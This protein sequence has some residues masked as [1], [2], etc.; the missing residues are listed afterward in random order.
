VEAIADSTLV[1]IAEQQCGESGGTICGQAIEVDV[2]ELEG[3]TAVGRFGWKDQHAS[4]L[5]FAADAYVNEMGITNRLI[6]DDVTS[7]C[8]IVPDPESHDIDNEGLQDIDHFARFMRG[9]KAPPRDPHLA[10]THEARAGERLFNQVGC[11][12]CHVDRIVTAPPGTPVDGGAFIVPPALGNKIIHPFSDFLLH[13]VGSGDGIVQNAGQETAQKLRTPPLWGV[14]TRP[15]LMHDGHSLT[16]PDAIL[17]HGGEAT[18]VIENFKALTAE[19]RR[20]IVTFL[21]SL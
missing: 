5:S 12:T 16:F 18:Q 20:H 3:A 6:P 1:A 7:L 8:D 15:E 9:S 19:Q 14:R 11:A 21:K 2:L 10:G 4:L 13:S 17:R